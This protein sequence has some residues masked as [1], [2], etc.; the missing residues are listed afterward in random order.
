MTKIVYHYTSPQSVYEILKNKSLWFTDCE[1]LNDKGELRYYQEPLG[2]A[3]RKFHEETDIDIGDID[4]FIKKSYTTYEDEQCSSLLRNETN[5]YRYYVLCASEDD[6]NVGLWNYYTKSKNA[7][8]YNLGICADTVKSAFHGNVS[9]VMCYA[10]NVIYDRIEQARV[11][12][13]KMKELYGR[14]EKQDDKSPCQ[15]ERFDEWF[16]VEISNFVN[17]R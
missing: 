12:F 3:W 4:D 6:D 14:W 11:F 9:D 2:D 10:G 5:Y 15:Y 1:Y 7:H 13:S 16:N 8:G 17:T